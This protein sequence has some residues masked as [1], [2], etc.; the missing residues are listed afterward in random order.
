MGSNEGNDDEKPVHTVALDVFRLDRTE[1]T[2][3]QYRHCVEAG[4]CE[5]SSFKDDDKFNG[6]NQPVVGVTWE[7]ARS[8]CQWAGGRLPT[9]AEWEYAARGAEGRT[10]PWGN[11]FD[12]TRLN[13]CDVNCEYDWADGKVDDGYARTAPVGSYPAG[14]NWCGALDLAGNVWEWVA[15]WYGSY[16]P[17]RQVNPAGPASGDT[18]VLRGGSWADEASFAR[19]AYR[20]GVGPDSRDDGGGFRCARS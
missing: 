10:F 19:C 17:G 12:G 14:A 6:D 16:P 13:Y 4:S 5:E 18:R 9:E 8:Y 11:E 20:F 1:V 3:A 7:D 2:N 15:D